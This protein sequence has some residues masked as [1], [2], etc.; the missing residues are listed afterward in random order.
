MST[1]AQR[2]EPAD[3]S[4]TAASR[5]IASRHMTNHIGVEAARNVLRSGGA[6]N[7]NRS[8][9]LAGIKKIAFVH[10][11]QSYRGSEKSGGTD[12]YVLKGTTN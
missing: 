6:L 8:S 7:R 3:V 12:L 9:L 10:T 1:W 4:S 2:V 11:R 5:K